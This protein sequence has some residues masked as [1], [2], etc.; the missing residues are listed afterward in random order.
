MTLRE[1]DV[2]L[3]VAEQPLRYMGLNVGTRMTVVRSQSKGELPN[4][5]LTIVSPIEL[6]NSLQTQ[7]DQ[8][9]TVTNLIA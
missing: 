5:L 8:L 6:S 2:D 3:W 1:L 7:L 9:G 4:S